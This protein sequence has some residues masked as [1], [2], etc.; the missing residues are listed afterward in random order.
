MSTAE[1]QL[2]KM[3]ALLTNLEQAL[4]DKDP[5]MPNHLREIHKHLIQFEELSH[6]LTEEQIGVILSGQA[7]KLNVVL[8]DETKKSKGKSSASALK[9]ITADDL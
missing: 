5:K 3:N 1:E 8:A 7:A 6:L 9:G 2:T 4:V